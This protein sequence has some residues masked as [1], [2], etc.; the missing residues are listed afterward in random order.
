MR[1]FFFSLT[2]LPL[3]NSVSAQSIRTEDF[4]RAGDDG[5]TFVK[6]PIAPVA[7]Q[8]PKGW[9]LRD[10]TRWAIVR[11]RCCSGKFIPVSRHRSITRTRR[12]R[13]ADPIPIKL[14]RDSWARTSKRFAS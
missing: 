10:G 14:C 3:C 12:K 9:T 13:R 11:P 5:I 4:I 7:F 2:V 1:A 8:L 6:D